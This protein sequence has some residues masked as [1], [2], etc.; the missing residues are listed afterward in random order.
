MICSL[1]GPTEFPVVMRQFVFAG[2]TAYLVT[3]STC[4]D[5]ANADL[6]RAES[7]GSMHAQLDTD[8]R[9]QVIPFADKRT[10]SGKTVKGRVGARFRRY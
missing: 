4:A 1:C 6:A 7:R 10:G 8:V 5:R 3:C 9:P 2:Q